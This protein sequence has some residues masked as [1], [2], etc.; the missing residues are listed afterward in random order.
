MF[1]VDEVPD[2]EPRY[3][4]APT[5]V[6]PVIYVDDGA[7]R[8][9]RAAWGLVPSWAKSK[10]IGMRMINARSETAC[11]KSAFRVAMRKRRCLVPVDGWYEWKRQGRSTQPFRFHRPD[12]A[13]MGLA[14]LYEH[15]MEP[16]SGEVLDSFTILTTA[17]NAFAA[18]T[19]D[20]MP[21]LLQKRDWSTWLDP[22][23]QRANVVQ[24]LCMPWM[25][26]DLIAT[27]V[28]RAVGNVRNDSVQLLAPVGL[29]PVQGDLFS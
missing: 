21:V 19:H 20:R 28:S 9:M 7:R 25:H 5:N 15:W 18:E 14:G 12:E 1:E 27:P 26:D 2:M 17:P 11:T 13:V 16:E 4:V 10:K 6:M 22:A 29:D 8:V 3:N 24:Q 23:E